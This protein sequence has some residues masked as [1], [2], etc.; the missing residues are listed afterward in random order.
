MD[1][2]NFKPAKTRINQQEKSELFASG[3]AWCSRCKSV[4]A[5]DDMAK[6]SSKSFGLSSCCKICDSKSSAERRDMIVPTDDSREKEN[7]Y[8]RAKRAE[9]AI[10]IRQSI[11]DNPSN[12]IPEGKHVSIIET[13]ALRSV[14]YKWCAKCSKSLLLENF[15]TG[16]AYCRD[17]CSEYR[18]ENI[19]KYKQR[20]RQY[21]L[22]NKLSI[23]SKAS[24]HRGDNREK[25]ISSK[26]EYYT[27][28]K[29]SVLLKN[30]AWRL[31][32]LDKVK[33][34]Q[35]DYYRR[36]KD[37]RRLNS[38][39]WRQNN[40][41]LLNKRFRDRYSSDLEFRLRRI[42]RQFVRRAYLSIGSQKELD[43]LTF[44]GYSPVQ[45]KEHI[46]S[47]FKPGMSW[48]NY[49]DWHIDHIVPISSATTFEEGIRLS[50]LENLQPLW[51]EENLVKGSKL[52]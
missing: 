49:G 19:D 32:N 18:I 46:E 37:A 34:T 36:N 28:N 3:Y 10:T 50:Q 2:L 47:L 35:K 29:E 6:N 51:A 13:E 43:T 22:D 4:V 38:Y 42:C 33:S 23:L 8:R 30:A 15:S 16:N 11:Y 45:L 14:G 17:C 41:S 21:Y 48:D 44:L 24:K 39:L 52:I 25:I 27:N 31:E 5:I 7:T 9:R 40:S 12:F 1:I 20:D 26:K